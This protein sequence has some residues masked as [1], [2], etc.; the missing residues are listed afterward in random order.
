VQPPR[1]RAKQP[2]LFSMASRAWHDRPPRMSAEIQIHILRAQSIFHIA[3]VFEVMPFSL[4]C[5][6]QGRRRRQSSA[7]LTV[8]KLLFFFSAAA[9]QRSCAICQLSVLS[10]QNRSISPQPTKTPTPHHSKIHPTAAQPPSLLHV[11][12]TAAGNCCSEMLGRYQRVIADSFQ[13][14]TPALL[15]Q[16]HTIASFFFFGCCGSGFWHQVWDANCYPVFGLFLVLRNPKPAGWWVSVKRDMSAK[17][18][19]LTGLMQTATPAMN[20]TSLPS[21]CIYLLQQLGN[22]SHRWVE[23]DTHGNKIISRDHAIKFPC[24]F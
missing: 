18:Q 20:I 4:F 11:S 19:A 17:R 15:R 6:R 3:G 24:K 10:L 14:C 22:A 12:G 2:P 7:C 8:C 16:L 13:L 5:I 9:K 21:A 1:R 23:K